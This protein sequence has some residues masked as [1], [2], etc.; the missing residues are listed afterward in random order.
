MSHLMNQSLLISE[1]DALLPVIKEI[2]ARC[3]TSRRV[4]FV[5]GNFNVV[6]PG[7]LRLLNFAAEC[8][9]FL[10]VGITDD[11]TPGA[12]IPAELRLEGVRAIN[13]VN[14]ALLLPI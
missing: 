1:P 3:P 7:H 14:Y 10:V 9:E 11:S 6:H 4:V 5:S 13:A 12:M 2:R 8:G